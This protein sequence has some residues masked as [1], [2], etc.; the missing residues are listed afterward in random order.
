MDVFNTNYNGC[1]CDF[2]FTYFDVDKF[3]RSSW[4][5][6]HH[7]ID[8]QGGSFRYQLKIAS[9]TMSIQATVGPTTESTIK[10]DNEKNSCE[11]VRIPNLRSIGNL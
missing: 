7:T 11:R 10:Q 3:I 9:D 5:K 1:S 4:F 6:V 8:D 2:F